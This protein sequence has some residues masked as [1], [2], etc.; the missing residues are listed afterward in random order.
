MSPSGRHPLKLMHDALKSQGAEH[1]LAGVDTDYWY[2]E[3]R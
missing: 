2:L 1:A 3:D